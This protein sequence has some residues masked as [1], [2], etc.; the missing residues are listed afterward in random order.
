MVKCPKCNKE[1]AKP[2]K[3]WKY[4]TFMVEAFLC[5]NCGTKFREYTK[6]GKHSFTLKLQGRQYLR[7]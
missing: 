5:S 3:E 1:V 2:V 4:H 7:A 6:D